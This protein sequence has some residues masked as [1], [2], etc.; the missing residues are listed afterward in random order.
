MNQPLNCIRSFAVFAVAGGLIS[1]PGALA[2]KNYEQELHPLE[3][4]C[5]SYVLKGVMQGSWEECSR[6]HGHERYEIQKTVVKMGPFSQEDNKRVVYIADKIYN[7]PEQGQATVADNPMY[8]DTVRTMKDTDPMALSQQMLESM[9]VRPTG[10][11]R[12]ILNRECKVASGQGITICMTDNGLVLYM[13]AMGQERTAVDINLDSGGND[14]N[15]AVPDDVQKAPDLSS[16]EE[17]MK[18]LG[19][20]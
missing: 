6:Y 10:E 2:A 8:E 20:Q 4:Y 11:K 17:M 19:K 16:I 12:E 15:Y 18:G 1:A 7:I 5:I 9:N 3:H 14:A 13:N